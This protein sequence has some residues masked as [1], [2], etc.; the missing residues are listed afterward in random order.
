MVIHISVQY[1]GGLLPDII[2]VTQS[3]LLPGCSEGLDAFRF[4]FQQKLAMFLLVKVFWGFAKKG[5]T[6]MFLRQ[7]GARLE[8]E[9]MRQQSRQD[10]QNATRLKGNL[11]VAIFACTGPAPFYLISRPKAA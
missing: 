3:M 2:L 8:N 11:W 1:N 6:S 5:Y 4:F 10:D 9:K 7:K